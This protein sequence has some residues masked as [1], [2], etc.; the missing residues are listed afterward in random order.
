MLKNFLENP[1]RLI[2]S[3]DKKICGYSALNKT[4]EMPR[5]FVKSCAEK[6][7]EVCA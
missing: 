4:L 3:C 5:Q 1:R 6:N 2:K 7:S